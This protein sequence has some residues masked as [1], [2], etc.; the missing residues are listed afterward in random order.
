MHPEGT[1]DPL[2]WEDVCGHY[3]ATC[4]VAQ[5][6][7]YWPSMLS[8][9]VELDGTITSGCARELAAMLLRAADACDASMAA[10]PG[11]RGEA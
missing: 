10:A 11:D 7:G 9:D 2:Y 8:F 6:D 5:G 1:P 3:Y 4:S